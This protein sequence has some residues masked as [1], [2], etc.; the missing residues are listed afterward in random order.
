M[1][2]VSS[3]LNKAQ[4]AAKVLKEMKVAVSEA[5]LYS[6]CD[7]CNGRCLVSVPVFVLRCMYVIKAAR[8]GNYGY[9]PEAIPDVCH[10]M[11]KAKYSVPCRFDISQNSLICHLG[12]DQI[13]IA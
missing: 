13:D 2:S 12:E 5:S 4:Q 8:K 10:D 1:L 11:V 9:G 3:S 7:E 6:R